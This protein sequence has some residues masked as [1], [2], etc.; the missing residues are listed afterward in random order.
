MQKL[1]KDIFVE[2]KFPGV[3]V[4]AVVGPDGVVCIDTPTHPADARAWRQQLELATGKPI[5]FVINLDHHRDR[6]LGNQWFEAPVIAHELTYERVRMLPELYRNMPAEAG[7]DSELVGDL[8][9]LRAVPPQI[10]FADRLTLVVGEREV[11]LVHRPGVTPGAVWVEIP[12]HG[13][14]FTGDAVTHKAPPFLL[15]A[16]LDPWLDALA[17]L[18]RKRTAARFIVPGRGAVT[19]KDGVKPTEDFLKLARRKAEAFV[20]SRKPRVELENVA[21]DLL[22]KAP[23]PAD[24]RHVYQRRIRAGLE[25][26][27]DQLTITPLK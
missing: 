7:A 3:T 26:L 12:S 17:E 20:R 27:Y 1:A 5:Q 21:R 14:V 25:H 4:G 24:L 6:T 23:G 16:D 11:H 19:N 13:V 2:T 22:G 8:S 18:R 9:G 10:T 15:D